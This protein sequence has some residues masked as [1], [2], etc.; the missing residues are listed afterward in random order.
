MYKKGKFKGRKLKIFLIS[1]AS[2][3]SFI[4]VGCGS[5][6]AYG[7]L[8]TYKE[9]PKFISKNSELISAYK[10]G[11]YDKNGNLIKLKG[12]N[13]GNLFLQEGWISPF[14][15]EPLKN[16]DGTLKKDKDKNIQYPEFA[17]ETF[18]VALLNNSHCG[19]KNIDEWLDYYYNSWWNESD[20]SN[21]KETGFN[22]I[23]LPFY[24]KQILNDDYSY[25][26][27]DVAFKYLD[28]FIEG[29]KRNN[30]YV[31]LDLHGAPKSQNGYEHS[32]TLIK[33]SGL[34]NDE[35]AIEATI[36]LWD[37][38]SNHYL[39]TR[40][41]L[42]STIAAYDLLNEPTNPHGGFSDEKCHEVYDM[43]YDEIRNNNDEHVISMEGCWGFNALPNPTKYGWTNVLYQ[44]HF[45]N[46]IND[47][48]P[49]PLFNTY[50][51]ILNI[52]RWYEVPTLI[53]EFTFF[54]DKDAWING[55]N[56]Y[57]KNHFSWT[58]WTYKTAITGT[59]DNSWGLYNAKLGLDVNKEETKCDVSKCDFDTFK[60]FCDK[61][62]TKNCESGFLKETMKNYFGS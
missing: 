35:K 3:I 57:D 61:I 27:E 44:Y 14:V 1:F 9:P 22:T 13:A 45:Y 54:H 40:K 31:I 39:T 60:K 52:G 38:V 51:A 33:E 7:D 5:L 28:K 30:L 48:L 17:E 59:R 11:L 19:I 23:R 56:H 36:N 4:L 58:I 50:N 43:I 2:I 46:W 26:K 18:R 62:N 42:S 12:I 10:N 25:K 24:W 55:L 49:Y 8:M 34:W 47:K 37:K 41:D 16:A 32:G 53:G 6:I 15:I 29:A 21:V 20:F